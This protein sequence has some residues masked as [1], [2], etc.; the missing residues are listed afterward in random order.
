MG[1]GAATGR[2]QLQA[3]RLTHQEH[4]RVGRPGRVPGATGVGHGRRGG[5]GRRSGAALHGSRACQ[6]AQMSERMLIS[7]GLRQP[8]DPPLWQ[9]A[10]GDM[11]LPI[12]R[13]RA[14]YRC[15]IRALGLGRHGGS[16]TT[17][18]GLPAP[19][20]VC[21]RKF[22]R[23]GTRRSWNESPLVFVS[24]LDTQCGVDGTRE[25][26]GL[27]T[28]GSAAPQPSATAPRLPPAAAAPPTTWLQPPC[29]RPPGWPSG[30][31][32]RRSRRA[33]AQTARCPA[34]RSSAL[35]GRD[36][37]GQGPTAQVRKRVGPHQKASEG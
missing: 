19:A 31:P 24:F 22:P 2:A 1:A 7:P 27:A 16:R 25:R 30:S 17:G 34:G 33:A 13:S 32:S 26:C 18:M 3:L 37:E 28:R 29:R 23:H 9:N 35:H 21:R 15:C 6:R 4:K 36:G 5:V 12:A 10:S 20:A 8:E 11:Q 14:P